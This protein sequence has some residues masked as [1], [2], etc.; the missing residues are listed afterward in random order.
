MRQP[1][2]I[3]TAIPSVEDT[4]SVLGV[5]RSRVKFLRGSQ[6]AW[7]NRTLTTPEPN[8][9]SHLAQGRRAVGK[10]AGLPRP[11][12]QVNLARSRSRPKSV[13]VNA[14]YDEDFTDLYPGIYRGSDGLRT[15]PASYARDTGWRSPPRSYYPVDRRMPLLGAAKRTRLAPHVPGKTYHRQ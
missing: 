9:G 11:A 6:S 4:A 5:S 3:G 15:D 8:L 7:L 14:P 10:G 1:V 13:F 2:V 12:P